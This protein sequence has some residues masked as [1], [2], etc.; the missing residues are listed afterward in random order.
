MTG[1]LNDDRWLRRG[2]S[3]LWDSSALA[4]LDV[5]GS[6]M[7]LR[8][9]L[10]ISTE[11][12]PDEEMV[13]MVRNDAVFVAGLDVS[14]DSMEPDTAEDW[15]QTIVFESIYEFQNEGWAGLV[16]WMPDQNRWKENYAEGTYEWILSTRYSNHSFPLGQCIWNGAQQDLTKIE[17]TR[18]GKQS[19]IGMHVD[20]IS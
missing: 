11:G 5:A 9:F 15:L 4:D 17:Q 16:F 8:T 1:V 2:V 7:S 10:R 14:I 18:S 12:W 19:V 20:R 3:V 6:V 13:P